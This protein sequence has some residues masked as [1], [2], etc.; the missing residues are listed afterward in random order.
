MRPLADR[1][2]SLPGTAEDGVKIWLVVVWYLAIVAGPMWRRYDARKLFRRPMSASWVIVFCSEDLGGWWGKD[3]APLPYRAMPG[4]LSH[5]WRGQISETC[6]CKGRRPRI[7]RNYGFRAG[8][9]PWHLIHI[10]LVGYR[11]FWAGLIYSNLMFCTIWGGLSGPPFFILGVYYF[12]AYRFC[13]IL[14]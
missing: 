9:N 5:Q 11:C 2:I 10:I 8:K 1:L 3:E 14:L 6:V 13:F 4:Q 12:V 7:N